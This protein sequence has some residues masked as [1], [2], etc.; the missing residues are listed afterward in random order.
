[1]KKI[2]IFID[3]FNNLFLHSTYADNTI[4]PLNVKKFVIEEMKDFAKF[5]IFL[6]L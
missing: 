6:W 1:M 3:T 5:P 4:F 2:E